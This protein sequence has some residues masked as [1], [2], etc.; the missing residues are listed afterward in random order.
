MNRVDDFLAMRMKEFA[1]RLKSLLGRVSVP[2][3]KRRLCDFSH[4]LRQ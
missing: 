3:K 4:Q 2:E 1:L